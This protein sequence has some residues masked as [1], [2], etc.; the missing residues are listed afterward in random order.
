[1]ST[2]EDWYTSLT[3]ARDENETLRQELAEAR[4]LVEHLAGLTDLAAR[5][6]VTKQAISNWSRRYAD[7]PEPILTLSA[8]SLWDEREVTAWRGRRA[9][10][11]HG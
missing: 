10:V 11:S 8:G 5:Y 4:A 9:A 3:E 2:P 6:G 1:M 7:F